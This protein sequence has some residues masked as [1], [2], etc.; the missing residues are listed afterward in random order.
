[1]DR[2]VNSRNNNRCSSNKPD[3]NNYNVIYYTVIGAFISM[4]VHIVSF[5]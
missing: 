2:S 4:F 1:M 3:D 5:I